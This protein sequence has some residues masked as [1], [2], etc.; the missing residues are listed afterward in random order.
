MPASVISASNMLCLGTP[1]RDALIDSSRPADTGSGYRHY[2]ARVILQRSPEAGVAELADAQ[3]LKSW[4]A[5]AA[6]GFDSRP[7]HSPRSRSVRCKGRF[8][9]A[10]LSA[11]CASAFG[12]DSHRASISL[13]LGSLPGT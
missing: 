13:T 2:S 10:R 8:S 9:G 6:C 11:R 5:Q 12:L 7:R 4:V 3:D 1:P